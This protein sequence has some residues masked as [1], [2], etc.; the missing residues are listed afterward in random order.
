[1]SF[2]PTNATTGFLDLPTCHGKPTGIPDFTMGKSPAVFDQLNEIVWVFNQPKQEWVGVSMPHPIAADRVR[3]TAAAGFNPLSLPWDAFFDLRYEVFSDNGSTPA[4]ESATVQLAKNQANPGSRDLSQ[5]T[6]GARAIYHLGANGKPYLT[7]D[8]SKYYDA[9]AIPCA[10]GLCTVHLLRFTAT[11]YHNIYDAA[12]NVMLWV[13]GSGKIQVNADVSFPV[14]PYNDG[15]WR[16]VVSH[17][18]KTGISARD[19]RLW[20][21]GKLVVDDW[22]GT[23]AAANTVVSMFNRNGAASYVGDVGP[24]GF[25]SF[26]PTDY[27]ADLT[28]W[29]L[30]QAPN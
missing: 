30:S 14:G 6:A 23:N 12:N 25:G 28:A 2:L 22:Q 17:T 19:N 7:F 1:M 24:F 21:D 15:E 5:A 4:V 9:L 18:R 27:V 16:C 26:D 20:I 10:E 3:T 11:G 13:D 29:M 8:G